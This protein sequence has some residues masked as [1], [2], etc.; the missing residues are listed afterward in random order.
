MKNSLFTA[1]FL[2]ALF[3]VPNAALAMFDQST[4]IDKTIVLIQA[5]GSDTEWISAADKNEVEALAAFADTYNKIVSKNNLTPE[6]LRQELTAAANAAINQRSTTFKGLYDVE[7]SSVIGSSIPELKM[8][9]YP[10]TNFGYSFQ[11]T[12]T[13]QG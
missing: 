6:Q 8:N 9:V 7:L 1:L 4:Q 13:P 12:F 5:N 10:Q 2:T 3:L 11:V